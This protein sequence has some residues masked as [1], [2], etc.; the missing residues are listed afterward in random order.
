MV[1][2]PLVACRAGSRM[3]TRLLVVSRHWPYLP[4]VCWHGADTTVHSGWGGGSVWPPMIP[5]PS[6]E[7]RT[8]TDEEWIEF[9][10]HVERRKVSIGTCGRAS[11]TP[12]IHEH[13]CVRCPCSGPTRPSATGSSRSA[14]T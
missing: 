4:A 3:V 1:G 11:G 6:E 9:L 5:S 10:G 2:R 7:Y 14:T 8:S 12:C 13:A